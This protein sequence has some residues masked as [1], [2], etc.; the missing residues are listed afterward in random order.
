M[1]VLYIDDDRINVLLFEETARFVPGLELETAASA[2]EALELAC[3]FGPDLLVIDLHLPDGDGFTLLPQLR[4]ALGRPDL[5]AVLCSADDTP[6]IAARAQAAGFAGRWPK[7]VEIPVVIA[8]LKR[9]GGT[10][11]GAA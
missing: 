2:A 6:E 5:P 4:A 3:R 8:E 11:S 7:P 1:K 10:A 9:L